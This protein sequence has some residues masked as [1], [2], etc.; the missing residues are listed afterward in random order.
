MDITRRTLVFWGAVYLLLLVPAELALRWIGDYEFGP[1]HA[2]ALLAMLGLLAGLH[3]VLSRGVASMLIA[4]AVVG[5]LFVRLLYMG[6]AHFSGAGFTDDFFIHLEWESVVVAWKEYRGLLL[7]TAAMLVAA[8]ALC[9]F[10]AR[11]VRPLRPLM[12]SVLVVISLG[13]LGWGRAAMPE[14]QL[15]RHAQA[16]YSPLIID[17]DEAVL[18]RWRHSGMVEVDLVPKRRVLARAPETPRNLVL[19][20]LE[21]VGARL[22]KHPDHPGLMPF[23]ERL[24]DEH[25]LLPSIHH[26]SYITIEGLVNS[27]CGTLFGFERGSEALLGYEG[28]AEE[29]PCLG[30]VLRAAG[31]RQAYLGGA[32]L[33]FAGKGDFLRSHGYDIAKGQIHWAE[34]GI[35]QR[36]GTWGVSDADLF[37]LAFD[38]IAELRATGRPF[39]LTLL[40]IGTHLPGY[41]YEECKPYA[42]GAPRFLDA[43]HCTDQLLQRFIE[44]LQSEGQLDDTLLAITA[45][46]HI[47]ASPGMRRLF[48]DAVIEDRR[49][50]LV[51]MGARSEKSLAVSSGAGYDL[52]PTVLDLLDIAHNARFALGRSLLS[53][54]GDRQHFLTRYHNISNGQASYP[55][56]AG[57]DEH[58]PDAA[59]PKLPLDRCG[60]SE[61]M[62]VLRHIH[63]AY[64]SPPL[65]LACNQPGETRILVPYD[66]SLPI[67][68][69]VSGADVAGSFLRDARPI[70]AHGRGLF[71][72]AVDE[73]GQVLERVFS[74][75][76]DIAQAPPQ[77]PGS[78]AHRGWLMAWREDS[79]TEAEQP[80]WIPHQ[81]NSGHMGAWLLDPRDGRVLATGV[82][83][84][85]GLELRIERENCAHLFAELQG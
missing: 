68:F 22:L 20:Y 12:A 4:T 79:N 3:A 5:A 60:K 65:Q 30:D 53:A 40:T 49:L 9:M 25:G 50:P 73:R 77:L 84:G 47:F 62:A 37:E 39:N 57:C 21:S 70:P 1:R 31:Y 36:P 58:K 18:E 19:V 15:L 33:G 48:G 11:R 74:P 10:A 17:I 44:R 51:V 69:S 16:W 26:S 82:E 23:F 85:H 55:E 13:V 38:E 7:A 24:V 61:L 64:S 6:V 46:H 43:V 76:P 67:E 59:A 35:H 42:P 75:S 56:D 83:N 2:W 52:A 80:T 32:D 71:L 41:A 66:P 63:A 54:G 8:A 45:D 78:E 27:M 29:L 28:M 14:W 34:R 72:L 81:S